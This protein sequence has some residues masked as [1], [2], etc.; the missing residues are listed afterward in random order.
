MSNRIKTVL[1]ALILCI[2]VAVGGCAPT[3]ADQPGAS[4]TVQETAAID[5]DNIP[6]YD[7]SPYVA[8]NDNIPLFSDSDLIT[9]AFEEYKFGRTCFGP[10][11]RP[12][13]F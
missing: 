7:G 11:C 8:I 13:V 6:A 2:S 1:A 12:E 5:L 10:G 4:T 9:E 3:S